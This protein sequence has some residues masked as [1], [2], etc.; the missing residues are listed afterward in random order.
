MQRHA[1]KADPGDAEPGSDYRPGIEHRHD[2]V[3]SRPEPRYCATGDSAGA[4]SP[5]SAKA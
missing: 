1:A 5:R 2:E 3:G 4:E